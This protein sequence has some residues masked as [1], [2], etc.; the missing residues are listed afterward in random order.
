MFLDYV[1]AEFAD[2]AEYQWL[3]GLMREAVAESSA[4]EV[5]AHRLDGVTSPPGFAAVV[6]IDKATSPLTAT[7]TEAC[8][9]LIVSHAE[10][11][12][13]TTSL[14]FFMNV[15]WNACL[16]SYAFAEAIDRFITEA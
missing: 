11:P 12:T 14:M 7:L 6:L 3:F 1:H 16:S 8:W 15:S 5:H 2:E 4:T 13:L 9:P 10:R